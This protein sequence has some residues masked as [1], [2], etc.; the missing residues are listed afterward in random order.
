MLR[1]SHNAIRR[2]ARPRNIPG[3]TFYDVKCKSKRMAG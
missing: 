3:L 1:I 2:A